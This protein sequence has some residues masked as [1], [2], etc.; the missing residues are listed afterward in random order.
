MARPNILIFLPETIRADAVLGPAESRARTPN[1]DRF[2]SQSSRFDN[3]FCQMA[4]CTPSRCSMFTGLYPHTAGHRSIWHLL[5]QGE[6]NLFQDLREGG[7]RTVV[8]GKNDLVDASFAPD[9]FDE[10]SLRVP[11]DSGS[12]KAVPSELGERLAPAMY[13]GRREGAC[14]DSD[15]ARTQSA[16]AFLEEEHDEPWCLFLPL[17]FAHPAYV[18]EE[19]YFSMHSRDAMPNPIPP[20]DLDRRRAYRRMYHEF[21]F[22]DGMSVADCREIKA[23]YYGMVSRVDAQFGQI[24]DKL[25]ERSLVDDTVVVFGSDHGDYAG[26]YGMVE[27]CPYGFDDCMLHVPLVIRAPGMGSAKVGALCE[28]TDLYPTLLE[29]AGIASRHHHFG[30]SLVPLMRGQCAAHREAVFAEGGRLSGEEHFGIGGLGAGSWYGRRA[31]LVAEDPETIAGRC[32]MVRTETHKYVYCVNDQDELFDL[33]ND[34]DEVVNV[35]DQPECE[36]VRRELHDRLLRWLLET[37]DTL[38]LQQGVRGWP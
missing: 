1:L 35:A 37:S 28:M 36:S 16:L 3:A 2:A 22:P 31:A 21:A 27:K 8:F 38:P 14:H 33:V 25:E 20:G 4:Y 15:W 32:A 24:L 9:C 10:W 13:S 26:D 19:P 5:Q 34:P 12:Y 6:R 17:S 23:L 30:R 18:A 11:G 29:L 7:Y